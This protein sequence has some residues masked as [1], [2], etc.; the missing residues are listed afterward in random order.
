M[1]LPKVTRVRFYLVI[2]TAAT[3][4]CLAL[5]P[6]TNSQQAIAHKVEIVGEVGATLHIEPNDT[7]RAGEEV[8]AWFALTQRGGQVIAEADSRC[9]LVVYAQPRTSNAAPV[10][11][12]AL[13]A[14]DAEGYRDIPGARFTF[15]KVGAYTL[16]LSCIPEQAGNFD[17]F[18]LDFE[19]TVAA[20]PAVSAPPSSETAETEATSPNA[21]PTSAAA[22]PVSK[23]VWLVGI[24]GLIL[25]S[26]IAVSIWQSR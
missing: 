10:L 7:P 23:F 1:H 3:L 24:V 8:L 5:S 12:P 6:M 4:I 14:V 19:V 11:T 9:E 25:L 16:L 20:G 13:T 26:A 2:A 18:E 22:S 17:P 21:A 15:P